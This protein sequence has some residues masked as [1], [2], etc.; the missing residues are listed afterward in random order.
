MSDNIHILYFASLGEQLKCDNENFTLGSTVTTIAELKT[1]LSQRGPQWEK[2]L[3]Q[4]TTKS[5]VNQMIADDTHAIAP[6]DEVAFFP[7]VTGG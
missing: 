2:S 4:S 5:A 7:P 6:G 1:Q 3:L